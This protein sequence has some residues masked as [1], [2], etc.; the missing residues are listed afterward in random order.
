[1]QRLRPTFHMSWRVPLGYWADDAH[2][3][4]LLA[5]IDEY[6]RL[7][8]EIALFETF[9]H[10]LYV[11]LDEYAG[12]AELLGQRLQQLRDCGVPSV[13]INVLTTIG[14]INE[15]WDYLPPLPFQP[16]IGHDGQASRG[17]ACPN[18]PELRAYIRE[19]YRL[20]AQAGPDFIWVDDDIRIQ[21]HGVPW[22]CFCPTCLSL[23]AQR[24]GR[25]WT[26]ESLVSAL[27]DPTQQ[28]V[29]AAWVAQ[30]SD[31][32]ASLLTDVRQA[33]DEVSPAIEKGL[34][35]AGAHWSA[36]SGPDH[37][38]WFE[39]L[40]ATKSRPGG[41]YYRDDPRTPLVGKAL[42]VGH[43]RAM[44]PEA[45]SDCQY[46]LE[47]FP[48]QR[49]AKA[50]A[51]V[52]NEFTLALAMGLNG[53]ACNWLHMWGC[54]DADFR[55]L[56]DAALPM[57]PV[58]ERLVEWTAD[59]PTVGLWGAW[60]WQAAARRVLRPGESWFSGPYNASLEPLALL[61][62]AAS[63][64]PA[65][66]CGSVLRGR[67]AEVLTEEELRR[68][69]SG[70][71]LMDSTALE[72]LQARGLGELT[73]VRLGARRDNGL[74]ER[75]TDDPL[76]GAF[77][78][79]LRDA[80]IEFWG[81]ARGQ[82]DELQ[83]LADSVRVLALLETYRHQ[84]HGPC[85][86]AF[87]NEL[88]GR[89]VVLGYAPWMFLQSAGKREQLLNA[90]DWLTGNALPVRVEP[91]A[92]ITPVVRLSP[93]RRKGGG[94]AAELGAGRSGGRHAA[95]TRSTGERAAAGAG[96][97]AGIGGAGGRAVDGSAATV[98]AMEHRV[99]ADWMTAVPAL[100]RPTLLSGS[101][102]MPDRS[103]GRTEAQSR[104]AAFRPS[105][106]YVPA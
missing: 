39:A 69:L 70:G 35:T 31:T 57:R 94:G 33:I 77:A 34:M 30:N 32:I 92:A 56:L 55:P 100:V 84:Q 24:T 73:G 86:T 3:A 18:T 90:A 87:E 7:V 85:V 102:G 72:V 54:H 62:I 10:H 96:G 19:K 49:L 71:V 76:N 61:G 9:T 93:D 5:L 50:A 41:G 75:F 105:A 23:F 53:I 42:D 78:G 15:A 45:V 82:G 79:D 4:D 52:N 37:A 25:E 40:G 28:P 67:T 104:P 51:T 103:V 68:L 44:L 22:P 74:M 13:G 91:T 29:R 26:R 83:P 106:D 27:E 89:V 2:F 11:P 64:D 99:R 81:D 66:A 38:R 20:T 36:Y 1:M 80:R 14:H 97:R 48:Y 21:H 16:M 58:W 17:C 59:L 12:Q 98:G 8:D 47:D 101:S 88:G 65:D 6:R 60:N 46:E 43:Q 95:D 63:V